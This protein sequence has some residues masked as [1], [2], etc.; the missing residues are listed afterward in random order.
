MIQIDSIAIPVRFQHLC[1][2]WYGGMDCMLY[3]IS[4]TGGLTLGG[5]RPRGCDT[6]EQWYYHIWR[7]LSCDVASARRAAEMGCN[8]RAGDDDGD[9]QG[10][11]ADYP[12]LCEFEAWVD[13]QS[14]RLCADY[15]LDDWE[16]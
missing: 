7:E 15:G 2:Q 6:D 12:A 8:Y 14:S 1:A 9:G 5:I 13:E 11:D 4:S 3:A 10:H 16:G